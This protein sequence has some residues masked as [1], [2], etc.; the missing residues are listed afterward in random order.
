MSKTE[1]KKE[2]I[3]PIQELKAC[4][5]MVAPEKLGWARI[6]IGKDPKTEYKKINGYT[7]KKFILYLCPADAWVNDMG[8]IMTPRDTSFRFIPKKLFT[9]GIKSK[10]GKS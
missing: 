8:D 10:G 9:V 6:E 3:V 2:K 1:I 7:P 4:L 5:I